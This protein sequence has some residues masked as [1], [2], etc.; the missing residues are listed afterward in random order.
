MVRPEHFIVFAGV[1]WVFSVGQSATGPWSPG[2]GRGSP[3]ATERSEACPL[4]RPGVRG[5]PVVPGREDPA[6]APG[7]VGG[8]CLRG[9]VG[10]VGAAPPQ[11]ISASAPCWCG[12]V[13]VGTGRRGRACPR[14][15]GRAGP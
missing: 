7:G 12:R 1:C 15:S 9:R 6:A 13:A 8:G 10:G 5:T 2:R 14:R 4:P 3:A 11:V